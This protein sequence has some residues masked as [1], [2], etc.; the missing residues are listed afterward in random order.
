MYLLEVDLMAKTEWVKQHF[1]YDE[2]H[3]A[4]I[5]MLMLRASQLDKLLDREYSIALSAET[6]PSGVLENKL[7]NEWYDYISQYGEK[8][9]S[10]IYKYAEALYEDDKYRFSYIWEAWRDENVDDF[11]EILRQK[12]DDDEYN[13]FYNYR[14][15]PYKVV[16]NWCKKLNYLL[17]LELQTDESKLR[18]II[19]M[20][21]EKKGIAGFSGINGKIDR[22]CRPE[23]M[24]LEQKLCLYKV[25]RCLKWDFNQKVL[26]SG[27]D[28]NPFSQITT[29]DEQSNFVKNL[30]SK[31]L[32]EADDNGI[33]QVEQLE[34]LLKKI[35]QKNYQKQYDGN[36]NLGLEELELIFLKHE[37]L[38]YYEKTGIEESEKLQFRDD[39]EIVAF[40][41]DYYRIKRKY[42]D[43]KTKFRKGFSNRLTLLR[44]PKEESEFM[45]EE[46]LSLIIDD[47]EK[48][49]Y[50]Q[51]KQWRRNCIEMEIRKLKD[52]R[53]WN[54][55][56][57]TLFSEKIY[58]QDMDVWKDTVSPLKN[59]KKMNIISAMAERNIRDIILTV[60][61][62]KG[63]DVLK[64]MNNI[65]RKTDCLAN[66][67]RSAVIRPTYSNYLPSI[68]EAYVNGLRRNILLTEIKTYNN[69]YAS[70]LENYLGYDEEE[71]RTI[72]KTDIKKCDDFVTKMEEL[73]KEKLTTKL[74]GSRVTEFDGKV[75]TVKRTIEWLNSTGMFSFDE[76]LYCDFKTVYDI[77]FS[78]K[79]SEELL[80]EKAAIKIRNIN[81]SKSSPDD[82]G[83][84]EKAYLIL[85]AFVSKLYNREDLD[86]NEFIEVSLAVV[87]VF[88]KIFHIFEI[89]NS[90]YLLILVNAFRE[91]CRMVIAES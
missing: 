24:F 81:G 60:D 31:I 57:G 10:K 9:N 40:L 72:I 6:L 36:V 33:F 49:T 79:L 28:P 43:D 12:L 41:K 58:A 14:Y 3:W 91:A 44:A 26:A 8:I 52:A 64:K 53:K 85:G 87:D 67:M 1:S 77:L 37:T 17:K 80:E 20:Y 68:H 23:V 90:D 39:E 78:F 29:I 48:D 69:I 54:L 47:D 5:D 34:A 21:I 61:T 25:Y 62:Y 51:M 38:K 46:M 13:A 32:R 42:Q 89:P 74:T 82:Y 73:T 7:I 86:E 71:K 22:F 27:L 35:S 65:R 66:T 15:E 11:G 84:D 16:G 45:I 83:E 59:C 75:K 88:H 4:L 55:V 63:E 56:K 50:H 19:N 70:I 2:L 30:L 76:S 18:K